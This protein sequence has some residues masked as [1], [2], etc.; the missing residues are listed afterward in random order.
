MGGAGLGR[1]TRVRVVVA[2]V[3]LVVTVAAVAAGP[4]AAKAQKVVSGA[5]HLSI[6]RARVTALTVQNVALA[7]ITPVSFRFV[8]TNALSWWFSVPMAAGGT[9]DYAATK[10]TFIH[11][12]GIRFVN[13][14][15]N[16]T[17]RLTGLRVVVNGPSSVVLSAA[18]GNAPV[19][20]ADVMTSTSSPAVT[21]QGKTV[22]IDGIQFKLTAAGV[23]A[24]QTA[25]GVTLDATT[26]F[27]EADL[28]FTLK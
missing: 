1:W 17:L 27:A 13:V 3:A 6:P 5:T 4:A 7:D 20:R 24:V 10:G 11:K 8:W 23:L 26:V 28:D 15:T 22:S 16:T 9:F 21:R 12:G 2:L 14:A 25:L 18:V 19:T